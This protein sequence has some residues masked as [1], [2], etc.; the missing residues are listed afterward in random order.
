MAFVIQMPHS[1]MALGPLHTDDGTPFRNV[2]DNCWS[3][4]RRIADCDKRGVDVHVL[5]TVPVMF[6]YWAKPEVRNH[7]SAFFHKHPCSR[8]VRLKYTIP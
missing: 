8:T 4:S 3:L 7:E 6:S 2:E 5:S 1:S